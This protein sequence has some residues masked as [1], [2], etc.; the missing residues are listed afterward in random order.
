MKVDARP[1]FCPRS[2]SLLECMRIVNEGA[3][4]TALIVDGDG[5]VLGILTD[6][7]IRRALLAGGSLK[8]RADSYANSDFVFGSVNDSPS[9]LM[10]KVD[11]RVWLLPLLDRNRRATE[12]FL[13][14]SQLHLPVAEPNLRGNEFKYLV[15]AFMSTWISSRGTYIDRFEAE[16]AQYCECSHGVTTSNG[17]VAIHLALSAL[18]VGD[19]DEV[20]VPDLTFGATIN[21]VIAAGAKP[22]IVDVEPKGWGIS[23]EHVAAAITARTKAIIPVHLYGQPCDMDP[24]M[25]IARSRGLYVIEDA[26]EAHGARY[27]GRRVGSIGDIGTYS[28]MANK[29]ITTGEGGMCVTNSSEL[30]ARMR[31]LRDHGMNRERRYWHETPG[32]NYRMTNLQA[33]IGVAQLERIDETLERKRRI[34]D[35]YRAALAEFEFVGFQPDLECRDRVVWLVCV[36][37]SDGRRDD[38]MAALTAAGLE[39]RPFFYSLSEMPVFRQY[40]HSGST[41]RAVSSIGLN[42]PTVKEADD[43]TV[44]LLRRI[45]T[46]S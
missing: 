11:E 6:G 38:Y 30:D 12:V 5:S 34:E 45:L 27:K 23:A 29:L 18:G 44:G 32:F 46:A 28:F 15:D 8:D 36:T 40:S 1:L 10:K 7:D 4:G 33:A 3:L 16:F 17:T 41:S 19:G 35:S 25:E 2:A 13:W 26:A 31:I 20:I 37:F 21:A 39:I 9:E 43:R 42:L 22:V 24:I 14:Q